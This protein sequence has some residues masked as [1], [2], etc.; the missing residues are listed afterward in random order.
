MTT[1]KTT[2]PLHLLSQRPSPLKLHCALRALKP[3]NAILR[4]LLNPRLQNRLMKIEIIH[5]PNPRNQHTRVPRRDA[6]HERAADG[7]E[8]V[9]HR[10]A[11]LDGFVLR[12]FGELLTA[13][14]VSGFGG[15]DDEVGGEHG[16]GDFA[17]VGAGADEGVD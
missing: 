4:K 11:G 12:E 14:L 17:A 10:I 5:S 1:S 2:T 13:A 16:G 8:V 7:A 9:F 6:I 3:T 15:L